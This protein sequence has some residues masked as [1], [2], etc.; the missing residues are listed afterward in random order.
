[1]SFIY[2]IS[3]ESL[4]KTFSRKKKRTYYLWDLILH[5][6]LKKSI[7]DLLTSTSSSCRPSSLRMIAGD[8]QVPRRGLLAFHFLWRR[9]CMGRQEPVRGSAEPA[10]WASF[11]EGMPAV[12]G[13]FVEGALVNIFGYRFVL[14]RY[15]AHLQPFYW[16]RLMWAVHSMHGH[17][18]IPKL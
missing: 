1:V 4:K 3:I 7:E 10:A 14:G 9:S 16:V 2:E 8:V 5:R 18:L 13:S 12:W 11:V 6:C 17:D 15:A